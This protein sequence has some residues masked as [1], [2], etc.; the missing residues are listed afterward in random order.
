MLPPEV[1]RPAI[2]PVFLLVASCAPQPSSPPQPPAAK[3][4]PE[5]RPAGTS[6]PA[7]RVNPPL[8]APVL[9]PYVVNSTL[10]GISITAV[11]FDSRSHRLV[12]ADQRGGPGSLWPDA[13]SAAASRNGSAAVNGGFFTPEGGPLGLVIGGG[14]RAGSLNRA[15]SL[16]AGMFV[17]DG[18]PALVRRESGGNGGEL[19]QSG[20]FLVED[21][22]AV[23]G[24]SPESSSARTFL[25]WDGGAGWFIARSGACSLAGLAAALEGRK[26]GGIKVRDVLN[27][28]GG[29]SSELWAGSPVAGGSFHQRPFWNKPVRNFLVLVPR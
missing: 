5:A 8:A 18:S 6:T 11:V 28:D 29:R 19:L 21:G 20:P 9:A 23:A 14:K 25:G 27:L 3:A 13:K 7:K 26:I 2:L 12:V 10:S 17:D 16:G 24:L 1:F 22:R 15:S 4:V